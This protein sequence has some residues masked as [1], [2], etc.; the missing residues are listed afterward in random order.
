M[1]GPDG[2]VLDRFQKRKVEPQ[3]AVGESVEDVGSEVLGPSERTGRISAGADV[4]E[5]T[6]KVG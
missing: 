4:G 1:G 2:Q 3:H 6:S 5:M